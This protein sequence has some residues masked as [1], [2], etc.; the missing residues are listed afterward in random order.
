MYEIQLC[1]VK[2]VHI[3]SSVFEKS[4]LVFSPPKSFYISDL[5]FPFL[6]GKG[7]L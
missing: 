1:I 7:K 5:I 3:E 4:K 2:E 6:L